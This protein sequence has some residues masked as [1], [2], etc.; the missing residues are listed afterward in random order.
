[1]STAI[2]TIDDVASA[3]TPAIVDYLCEK[4]IQ[5]VMFAVGQNVERFYDEAIYALRKGMIL[6]NHSYSHIHFSEESYERCVEEIERAEEVLDRLYRD[7]GIPRQYR[8]FRFP[9]GD[10][11]KEENGSFAHYETLQAYLTSHGFSKLDDR[12]ITAPWYQQSCLPQDVDTFWTF[13]FAEYMMHHDKSFT[14][15]TVYQRIHDAHPAQGAALLEE[16]SHHIIL[17][18]AHDETDALVP[19]YYA[20]FLDHCLDCGV[21]FVTPGFIG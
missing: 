14:A 9:Y 15:E 21:Q 2:L 18:H 7:A 19:R 3:N 6:G 1:M 20:Q 13:D 10:K 11:G 16:G 8:P 4:N 5:A 17:L 12:Q